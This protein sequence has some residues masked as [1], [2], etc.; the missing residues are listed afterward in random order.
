MHLSLNWLKQYV[1]LPKGLSAKKLAHDLTMSTVEVESVEN[2]AE[3]FENIVVGKIIEFK[4]HPNADKLK[5]VMVNIGTG[6]QAQI[7]CGGTNLKEGMLVAVALPGSKVRR[8]G[9]GEMVTLEKATLRGVESFGM[10][11]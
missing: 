6:R 5:I 2:Q 11:C 3:K 4:N 10:I 7:V 1:N 8:H 9:E